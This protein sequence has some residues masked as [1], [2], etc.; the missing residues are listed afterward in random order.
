[1]NISVGFSRD[2]LGFWFTDFSKV[3]YLK[4]YHFLTTV[5]IQVSHFVLEPSMTSIGHAL[6]QYGAYEATRQFRYI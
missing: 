4:R 5:C 1:M 6:A 2:F 3:V